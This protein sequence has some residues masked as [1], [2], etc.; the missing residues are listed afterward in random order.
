MT[1][2]DYECM[3]QVIKDAKTDTDRVTTE[4]H[5]KKDNAL[6]SEILHDRIQ[7]I[8]DRMADNFK[9]ENPRFDR[10]KFMKACGLDDL[11]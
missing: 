1:R 9:A 11:E 7:K 3:A 2:K 6:Q 10:D 8:A 4:Y 5:L